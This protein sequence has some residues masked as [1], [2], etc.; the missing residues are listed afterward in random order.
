VDEND[1]AIFRE[2]RDLQREH[3]DEYRRVTERS[4]S[5]QEK[6]VARQEQVATLYRRVVLV[7]AF[8]MAGVFAFLLYAFSK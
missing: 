2:I 4:L 7:A 6:A 1:R 8:L 5:L 3:L